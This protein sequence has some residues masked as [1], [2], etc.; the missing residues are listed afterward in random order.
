LAV[1]R[2]VLT[3]LKVAVSCVPTAVMAVMI[4]TEMSAAIR[5]LLD[6]RGP[7]F[8][9]KERRKGKDTTLEGAIHLICPRFRMVGHRSASRSARPSPP[10]YC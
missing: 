9:L 3:E 4:T 10:E 8:V 5:P 7:G 2:A 6:G 1:E